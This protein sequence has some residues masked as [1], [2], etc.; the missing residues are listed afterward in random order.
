[1][2][3]KAR[4]D[5]Q[6]KLKVFEYAA[7]IGNIRKTCRYFGISRSNYYEWKKRYNQ[8]GEAGLINSKPCPQNPHLRTP[9]HIAEKILYLRQ[10][11]HFGPRRI[12]MYLDRYHQIKVGEHE[13][14]ESCLGLVFV[15][16][17]VIRREDLQALP[18]SS[19]KNRFPDTISRWMS[20]S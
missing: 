15:S 16:C 6:R 20:S 2:D 9:D 3:A 13:V 8:K 11:Y 7:K 19:T 4:R 17:P 14:R 1:M 10:T 18:F 5:I 12:V